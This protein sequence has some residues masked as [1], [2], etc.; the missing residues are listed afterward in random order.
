MTRYEIV[1][2]E[3]NPGMGVVQSFPDRQAGQARLDYFERFRP[4]MLES[5]RP[6]RAGRPKLVHYLRLVEVADA[7]EPHSSGETP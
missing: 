5:R 4:P 6:G 2:R 7:A 1:D 3:G